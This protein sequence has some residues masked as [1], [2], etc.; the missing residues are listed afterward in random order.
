MSK[1]LRWAC[2]IAWVAAASGCTT[3]LNTNTT[4]PPAIIS[5]G[6]QVDSYLDLMQRLGIS[7]PVQQS[8]LF[9]AVERAYTEAPTST[10]TLRYAA[11]L[12]MP[13]HPSS[14]PGAG[15]KV[16]ETLLAAPER[17]LVSER[18]LA[19]VLLQHTEAR[20]KLDAEVRRLLATVDERT[21]G[22][23]NLDRR[24]QTLTEENA[25]LRKALE[26]AQAK[27]DAIRDIERSIIERTPTPPPAGTPG[28]RSESSVETQSAPAG[29]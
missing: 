6:N 14:D 7:D 26:E 1:A 18:L 24:T 17:L 4:M 2:T 9:H 16:L 13:G 19:S 8:D 28:A 15:K 11:A 27:L 29:R 12:V 20:L 3:P 10:N 5:P 22:Q 21:R 23:A 25:R